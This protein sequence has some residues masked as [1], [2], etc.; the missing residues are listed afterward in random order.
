MNT[1]TAFPTELPSQKIA[2]D[3]ATSVL[4]RAI[5]HDDKKLLKEAYGRLSARSR[6]QRFGKAARDLSSAELNYLTEVDN[7]HHVAL[8]AI[9]L[10]DGKER[11]VGVARYVR[12]DSDPV[13]AEAAVTVADS[14]RG[15]G[16]GTLLLTRLAQSA[17]S[18]GVQRF[19]A[20]VFWDNAPVLK[21]IR[22]FGAAVRFLGSGMIRVTGPVPEIGG[23]V[24]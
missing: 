18:N 5:Q 9:A 8:I 13:C 2:L 3:D 16:L 14:Y 17:R 11:A 4:I 23:G 21:L 24:P 6:Y 10:D 12:A 19:M 15:R 1:T 20:F 7:R 22:D